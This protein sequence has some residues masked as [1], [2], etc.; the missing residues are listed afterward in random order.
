WIPSERRGKGSRSSP[1]RR[2]ARLSAEP[3]PSFVSFV[4]FVSFVFLPE[5]FRRTARAEVQ[6]AAANVPRYAILAAELQKIGRRAGRRRHQ[7]H[8][9][10]NRALD[11]KV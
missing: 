1:N 2:R 4:P 11:R 10:A 5:R 6:H 9:R 7:R 3:M 8:R